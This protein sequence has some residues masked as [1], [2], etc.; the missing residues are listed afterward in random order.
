MN[1][2][3]PGTG[4]FTPAGSGGAGPAGRGNRIADCAAN[5][6]L[7]VARYRPPN[8]PTAATARVVPDATRNDRRAVALP[9][10][11]II[12]PDDGTSAPRGFGALAAVP[13]RSGGCSLPASPV[14]GRS[15]AR[16][17]R[18]PPEAGLPDMSR[19]AAGAVPASSRARG[20]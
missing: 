2:L 1:G 14:Q 9:P 6:F 3:M 5:T 7:P 13:G 20:T 17:S 19:P 15:G 10:G 4:R 16:K 11:R 18:A 12:A 8:S